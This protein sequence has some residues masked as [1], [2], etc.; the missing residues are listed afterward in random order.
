M[1]RAEV[2]NVLKPMSGGGDMGFGRVLLDLLLEGES[3]VPELRAV[4]EQCCEEGEAGAEEKPCAGFGDC[5]GGVDLEVDG[6]DGV[7]RV[8]VGAAEDGEEAG[9]GAGGDD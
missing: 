9:V 3:S 6:G 1:L 7:L 2:L 5:G 8:S 4:I